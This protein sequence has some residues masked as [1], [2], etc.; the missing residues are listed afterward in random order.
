M[1]MVRKVVIGV[2]SVVVVLVLAVVGVDL[3]SLR[4]GMPDLPPELEA[5]RSEAHGVGEAR[6]LS[7]PGG[8][9]AVLF[10]VHTS[11]VRVEVWPDDDSWPVEG[12]FLEVGTSGV[13]GSCT[14]A[15]L[16]THPGWSGRKDGGQTGWALLHLSCPPRPTATPSETATTGG[17]APPSATPSATASAGGSH[18]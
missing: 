11:G 17:S 4:P 3:W 10:T 14:V 12:R 16:E 7:V 8:W 15:V 2:V 5:L 6:P 13:I 9:N 1:T 18:H